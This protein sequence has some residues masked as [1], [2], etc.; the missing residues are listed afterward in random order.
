MVPSPGSATA[1]FTVICCLVYSTLNKVNKPHDTNFTR[2]ISR[3]VN[4]AAFLCKKARFMPFRKHLGTRNF[5]L[6][7]HFD[8]V[9]I[10]SFL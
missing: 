1:Q 2:V 3:V 4:R 6:D 8:K 10:P 9:G 7:L 5:K